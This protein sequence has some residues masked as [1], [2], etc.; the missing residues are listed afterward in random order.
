MCSGNSFW[1]AGKL[2]IE[3]VL[4]LI[5]DNGA[6]NTQE[7]GLSGGD[8]CPARPRGAAG[9]G[10]DTSLP[11]LPGRQGDA[12]CP[13]AESEGTAAVEPTGHR[14]AGRGGSRRWRRRGAG[15]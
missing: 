4:P 9:G 15:S 12:S 14:T 13:Y 3:D 1:G 2:F 8:P 6:L 5:R 11:S 7:R 10:I